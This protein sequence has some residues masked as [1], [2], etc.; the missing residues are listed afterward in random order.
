MSGM[1]RGDLDDAG[2]T[3]HVG[4]LLQGVGRALLVHELRAQID[5]ARDSHPA[6]RVD[7]D[8]VFIQPFQGQGGSSPWTPQAWGG[9]L[10]GG[11]LDFF[12]LPMGQ[13]YP[14]QALVASGKGGEGQGEPVLLLR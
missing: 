3:G 4:H 12:F 8:P 11:L 13:G 6:R 14:C 2:Q 5:Q 10:R 7:P 1:A 9:R